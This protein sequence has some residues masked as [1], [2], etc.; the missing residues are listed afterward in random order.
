MQNFVAYHG[1]QKTYSAG[2]TFG[3]LKTHPEGIHVGS[4]AQ[5]RMRAG[6]GTVLRV[7]V[8]VGHLHGAI[9]KVRDQELTWQKTLE[10]RRGR[11]QVILTYLNRYEGIPVERV[12]I[13]SDEDPCVV[14]RMSDKNF[15]KLVPEAEHSWVILDPDLIEILGQEKNK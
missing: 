2:F 7:Q 1:M 6:S 5:A 4:L 15:A 11:R 13:M 10:S 8:K 9:P 3:G 14:D 12:I